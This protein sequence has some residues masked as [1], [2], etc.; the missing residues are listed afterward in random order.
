MIKSHLL[1]CGW[2]YEDMDKPII[3]I[4]NSWNEFNHGHMPQRQ[5]ADKVKEGILAAGGLPLEFNTIGPCDALAQGYEGMSYILPSRDIIADSVE[6]MLR[7]HAIVD[8]VVLIASCDKITP[9]M[10][11]AALRLDLPSVHICSGTCMPSIS[12]AASKTLRKEFLDGKIDERTMAEG[13]AELYPHPGVCPY[14]GTANSMDIFAEALGMSLP[15]SATIPA[16]TN[17]R[18]RCAIQTGQLAVE[19]ALT[20]RKPSQIVTEA[21][22][23]NALTVLAA[24]SG[25]LNHLIHA[26]AV[27][28]Q[29][30][31]EIDFDVIG[32]INARTPQLCAV[33]P[34]G[35]HSIVDLH[36]AGGVPAVLKELLP[37]LEPG[38]VNLQGRT[39]EQIAGQAV[40]RD[41][42]V[43]HPLNDPI[44]AQGGIVILKGNIARQGAA[45][46]LSTIPADMHYFRGPAAVFNSEELATAAVEAGQIAEGSL[47]VVRYE[48]PKGGPGMREMH[49][50]AGAFVGKRIAIVTDGRFSGATG[51]LSIGYL[52]PE[53]ALGGEIAIVEN[54]DEIIID[55][56]R[57]SIHLNVTDE[58]L[59]TRMQNVKPALKEVET[60]L[61]KNYARDVG[62]TFNGALTS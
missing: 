46:R 47:V 62:S 26:P 6:A 29:A 45:M 17:E 33:N 23:R 25:S 7:S 18:M 44:S 41:P 59:Q 52:S 37:L 49:R 54:G 43:I 2:R 32:E 9:G 58:T 12:F 40:N 48:G 8:G 28:R 5:I 55:V 19:L 60:R 51:G 31:V 27:A 13:N 11:M 57:R 56:D 22:V 10:L 61:L 39:V 34:S 21:S 30:G 14:M 3:A 15:G 53:A 42:A 24:L 35:P 36:R 20:G 4:A 50:L 1:A 38:C 16:A